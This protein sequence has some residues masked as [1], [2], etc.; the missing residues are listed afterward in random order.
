MQDD[1][2][3]D[4]IFEAEKKEYLEYHSYRDVLSNLHQ[5]PSISDKDI[6]RCGKKLTL[7]AGGMIGFDKGISNFLN[8]LNKDGNAMFLLSEVTAENRR[9][10]KSRIVFPNICTPHL[11]AKEMVIKGMD[12]PIDDEIVK[13]V[14]SFDYL[15][16]AAI[17]FESRY[18]GSLGKGYAYS[19][20]WNAYEYLCDVITK[21]D[22]KKVVMWNEFYAFHTILNGICKEKNIPILYME[23]GCLPGTF[24]IEKYG[25][26]GESLPA[27]ASFLYNLL[28]ISK[29][30]IIN[31]Q[32]VLD[33]LLCTGLNR[34]IQPSGE[35]ILS[36]LKYYVPG[37]KTIVFY[38]Q[39]EYESG[40]FPYTKKSKHSHSPIFENSDQAV[41]YLSEIAER[42]EW[43]IIFKPHPTMV[44]LGFYDGWE[45]EGVDLVNEVD[46]NKLIDF[47]D[48]NIT[49]LSQTAY[50][51]AIR[52]KPTVLLGYMQLRGKGCVYEVYKKF[53]IE[54]TI[55]E[56]I[57]NGVTKSQ[58]KHFIRHCAQLL[59]YYLYDDLTHEDIPWGMR[60]NKKI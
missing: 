5:R 15:Y 1:M 60:V 8:K 6:K 43:N 22:P 10:T 16:Q 13:K 48:V 58:E 52:K 50:I 56:A 59:K 27:R 4:I 9:Y 24:C 55:S 21:L 29:H 40:M 45:R 2:N 42:N 19:F 37:R 12:I 54:A 36:K 57:S 33:H 26:Q 20:V 51:S 25:Q 46:I 11:F 31:T 23:F 47:A 44:N 7:V 3:E 39:N 34:N 14:E 53:Q 41:L 35:V 17:N 38:G 28:P 18:M 32:M 30:E 49:I